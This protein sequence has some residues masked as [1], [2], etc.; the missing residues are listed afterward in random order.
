MTC[1]HA[2]PTMTH[3][4]CG[5]CNEALRRT[6]NELADLDLGPNGV[7]MLMESIRKIATAYAQ[8]ASA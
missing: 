2:D 6:F 7:D 3:A 1:D 4:E 5:V 8:G